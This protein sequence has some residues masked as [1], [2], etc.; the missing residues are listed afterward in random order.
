MN[1]RFP[2]IPAIS[3]WMDL[4]AAY[5]LIGSIRVN[6]RVH[7]YDFHVDDERPTCGAERIA[8]SVIPTLGTDER[9]V[10]S[11]AT[12]VATNGTRYEAP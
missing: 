11:M 5:R 1:V 10:T 4:A 12:T 2:P 8:P 6:T 3:L 9:G 7:F